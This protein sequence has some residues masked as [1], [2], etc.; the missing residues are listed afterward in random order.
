MC[1]NFQNSGQ[2]IEIFWEKV[3]SSTFSFALERYGT[4]PDLH[5]LN[6]DLDPVRQNDADPTRSG[7]TALLNTDTNSLEI[8]LNNFINIS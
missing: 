4:D 1:H 6:A 5:A 7:S 3:S 2:H 8:V